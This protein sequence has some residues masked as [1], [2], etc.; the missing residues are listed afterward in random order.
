MA[1]TLAR[2]TWLLALGDLVQDRPAK[3][4]VPVFLGDAMQWNLRRYLGGADVLVDVPGGQPLHIPAGFAED[5]AVFEQGLDAL[6][7]GLLG[8][9]TPGAVGQALRRIEGAAPA[10]ADRLASGPSCSATWCVRSG[11][12]ARSSGP[13]C[14][15]ATRPGSSIATSAPA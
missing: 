15:S 10:D 8:N 9:A 3:L 11:C 4:T 12:P 7:Q 1:V 2:V 13:T 5:Q 14:W 6:N